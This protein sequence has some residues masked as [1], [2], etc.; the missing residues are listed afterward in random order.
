MGL[1]RRPEGSW[2][3]GVPTP[4]PARGILA[5]G[6]LVAHVAIGADP[7][8]EAEPRAG[9]A[10][11]TAAVLAAVLAATSRRLVA[12]AG[13]LPLPLLLPSA[14]ATA[15]LLLET[16]AAAGLNRARGRVAPARAAVGGRRQAGPREEGGSVG[17]LLLVG[18]AKF[19]QGEHVAGL[20]E[21]QEAGGGVGDVVGGV[22]V[23]RVEAA[24]EI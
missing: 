3:K 9:G 21:G 7:W 2:S 14:A 24:E 15:L 6:L 22:G 4:T 20:S 17:D 5:V 13:L 8:T 18:E 11:W 1:R 12:A 19:F 10:R 23:A 16:A